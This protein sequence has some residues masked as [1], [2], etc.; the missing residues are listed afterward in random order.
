MINPMHRF[1]TSEIDLG[2]VM[3][4]TPYAIGFKPERT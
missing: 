2:K 3:D 4:S 1:D